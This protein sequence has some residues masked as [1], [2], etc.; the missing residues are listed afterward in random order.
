[1]TRIGS[2]NLLMAYTH[3]AHDCIVGDHAI[4]ANATALSGHVEIQ[5][6]A[7]LGGFAGVHQFCRVGE[8]AFVGAVTKVTMDVLPYS[9]TEGNPARVYGIN[10]VGLKRRGFGPEALA[11][12][13]KAFRTLLQSQL[14]VSD[15][16]SQL[17]AQ[18]PDT[19]EVRTLLRFIRAARRGVVSRR[20]VASADT[21]AS[22]PADEPGRA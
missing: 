7:N 15:A 3:V 9:K 12:L 22:G 4:L 8:H 17:E 1:V 11:A 2:D 20:P 6:Y 18:G 19:A 16:V 21:T 13:R 5:D 10:S 14:T